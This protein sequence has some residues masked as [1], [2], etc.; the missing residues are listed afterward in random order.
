MRQ[1]DGPTCSRLSLIP[2]Q[3]LSEFLRLYEVPVLSS[4][5]S[6]HEVRYICSLLLINTNVAVGF[7]RANKPLDLLP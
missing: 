5:G 1:N 3:S 7:R 4:S 2:A 6:K